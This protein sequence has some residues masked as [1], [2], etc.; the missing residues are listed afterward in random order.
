MA[1]FTI[2]CIR[3]ATEIAM[4]LDDLA[5][6]SEFEDEDLICEDGE[7]EFEL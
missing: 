1:V 7:E 3:Y 2:D 6:T 5:M 4:Q